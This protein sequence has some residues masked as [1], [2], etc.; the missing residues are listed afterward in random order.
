M[1]WKSWF[2]FSCVALVATLAPRPAAAQLAPLGGHY[3]AKSSDTGYEGDVNSSGGY[4]ALVPFDFPAA[5][6]N[7][8]IP[9]QLVYGDRGVGAAGAGW[10]IPLSYI[11][12]DTTLAKRRPVGVS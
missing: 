9:V 3:G 11:Q 7:M 10:D 4:R 6:G 12:R 2:V 5:R 1:T 8:P